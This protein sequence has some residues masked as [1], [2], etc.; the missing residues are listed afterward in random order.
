MH[1][2]THKNLFISR[3]VL[4]QALMWIYWQIFLVAS[5]H[6]HPYRIH[7]AVE[8][9]VCVKLVMHILGLHLL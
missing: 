7:L 9:S 1:I 3:S 5:C 6:A 4:T 8:N 2:V